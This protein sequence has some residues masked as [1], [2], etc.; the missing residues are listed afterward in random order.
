MAKKPKPDDPEQSKRFIETAKALE[1]DETGEAFERAF[2]K[3][4]STKTPKKGA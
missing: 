3:V 2:K 1:S 4:V